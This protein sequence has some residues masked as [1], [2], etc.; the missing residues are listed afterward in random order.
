[1]TSWVGIDPGLDGAVACVDSNGSLE[2]VFDI[3]TKTSGVRKN[4]K[5]KRV[6][7]G[8][9]L[10]DI[11]RAW[12]EDSPLLVTIER[13][14]A[15]P[16]AGTVSMFTFGETYGI[17]QGVMAGLD[18]GYNLVPASVWKSHMGLAGGRGNKGDSVERANAQWPGT[19]WFTRKKDADRAE[20]ALLAL[21]AQS[22]FG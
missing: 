5:P 11:L 14:Q 1:M 19:E 22:K 16:Q 20:A 2:D 4:G 9:M 18:L 12:N 6:L 7:D 10:A 21:Y 3:P 17:I 13:V 15:S 8:H